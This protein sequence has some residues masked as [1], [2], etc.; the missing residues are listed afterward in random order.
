MHLPTLLRD[1]LSPGTR[2]DKD[3]YEIEYALGWGGFGITY[4]ARHL[5]LEQPVAIKKYYPQEL[6][7][8]DIYFYGEPYCSPKPSGYVPTLVRPVLARRADLGATQPS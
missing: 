8:R 4:R 3:T 5:I 1:V 7:H 2:L 6:V